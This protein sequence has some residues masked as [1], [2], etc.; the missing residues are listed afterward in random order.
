MPYALVGFFRQQHLRQLGLL[1]GLL[2]L[3]MLPGRLVA[4]GSGRI[5]GTVLHDGQGVATHRIMLIRFGSE[6]AV[7]RTPGQT[8]AQGR[9]VFE[10]LDTRATFTYFVGIRYAGQLYRSEPITLQGLSQRPD[11]VLDVSAASPQTGDN[12]AQSP[13][14]ITN[15]L[16]VMVGQGQQV[17]VREVIRLVNEASTT[18]EGEASRPG[19]ARISFHVPLPKGYNHFQS[20][21]GLAPEHTVQHPSGLYY[22]ASLAP[23]E[24]RFVYTY[25]L[26]MPDDVLMIFPERTLATDSLD[27][28]I[29]DTSLIAS[30]GLDFGGYVTIA[31]RLLAHFRGV[32]LAPQARSWIQLARRS[33]TPLWLHVGTYSVILGLA[34]LGILSPLVGVWRRRV[35][36]GISP[37]DSQQHQQALRTTE[38]LLLHHLARL[39]DEH[40]DGKL[41]E[42]SYQVQRQRHKQQLYE[43]MLQLSQAQETPGKKE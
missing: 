5:Q 19:A 1:G 10:G 32:N 27:I 39:D 29:D 2:V 21:Q 12:A 28:L 31:P 8:D 41:D 7:D 4:E 37:Q 17:E 20:V 40:H 6:G 24:H 16:I 43:V 36:M 33:T 38:S 18:Y 3:S 42:G 9:F 25:T 11:V 22:T 26:P 15:H 23:G 35:D 14:R 13:L 30:S 34:S